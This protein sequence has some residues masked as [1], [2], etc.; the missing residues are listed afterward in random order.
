VSWFLLIILKG[1]WLATSAVVWFDRQLAQAFRGAGGAEEQAAEEGFKKQGCTLSGP[2]H[3]AGVLWKGP[4]YS[5]HSCSLL[6][7]YKWPF[8]FTT[9]KICVWRNRNGFYCCCF[10]FSPHYGCWFCSVGAEHWHR[11]ENIRC[12]VSLLFSKSRYIRA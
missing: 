10:S 4:T 3:T 12:I 2:L 8:R 11:I 6:S 7:F 9:S 1:S 5:S